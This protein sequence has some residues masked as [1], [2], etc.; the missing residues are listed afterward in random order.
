MSLSAQHPHPAL[1]LEGEVYPPL[2]APKVTRGIG[3][4]EKRKG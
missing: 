4:A 2:A 3:G 1:P